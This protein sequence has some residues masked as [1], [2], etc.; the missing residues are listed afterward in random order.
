MNMVMGKLD[1]STKTMIN[2]VAKT[3]IVAEK[4][5]K[6]EKSRDGK[7][8]LLGRRIV[9]LTIFTAVIIAY[10]YIGGLAQ[11][12]PQKQNP[13]TMRS[14]HEWINDHTTSDRKQMIENVLR[15]RG[16]KE[17]LCTSISSTILEES[18]KTDIPVEMYLAIMQT[19][20]NFSSNA[21]SPAYAK[22][23][24]QIQMG[25]WNAY[26][27]KHKLQVKREQIFHPQSNIMVA[28]VILQELHKLYSKRGYKDP[29]IWDFVL[30]A[31]YAGPA[32][33]KDG[34]KDYHLQYIEKVRQNYN[35]FETQLAA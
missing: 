17:E 3:K 15:A 8:N 1:I 26:V 2:D 27:K 16:V 14:I 11:A 34:L 10:A 31:Y 22:G 5:L 28:S 19:E 24:M 12:E 35:E 21:V 30:A 25:T 23:I 18:R 9:L 4:K 32:S 29:V 7:N 20:S 33:L 13:S 6:K